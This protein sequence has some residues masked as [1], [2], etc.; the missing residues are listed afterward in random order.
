MGCPG[1]CIKQGKKKVNKAITKASNI[2]DGWTNLILPDN[3]TE[4][5]AMQRLIV[6][7]ECE[8]KELLIVVKGIPHYYC[9]ACD[10][11]IKCPCATKCRAINERCPK[12]KW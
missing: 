10:T 3:N 4:F 6:C 12:G 2:I 1:G 11:W 5:L 8:H 9:T 7:N